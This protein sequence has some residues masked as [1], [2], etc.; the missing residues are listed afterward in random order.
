M[1]VRLSTIVGFVLIAFACTSQVSADWFFG[2]FSS[3]ARDVK[4]RQCWP[5]PFTHPDRVAARAPYVTMV[6]NGWR[7]QNM[8]GEYHFESGTGQLNEAGK[9]RV[10]WILTAGPE[11]YRSIYVHRAETDQETS[12]RIASV[13]RLA[14]TI[15]PKDL[16]PVIPTSIS[17]QGWPADSVDAI[18]RKWRATMPPPRL[19]AP[20]SSSTSSGTGAT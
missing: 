8:L 14:A 18:G 2:F 5:E 3:I 11:Q 6:S 12:A 9:V 19:P 15:S 10:R 7:R 17:D 4:R 13:M 1:P 16:P 20:A